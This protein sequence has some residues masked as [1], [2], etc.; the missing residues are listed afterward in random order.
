MSSLEVHVVDEIFF[1]SSVAFFMV[2]ALVLIHFSV[3]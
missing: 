1:L 3:I 2:L